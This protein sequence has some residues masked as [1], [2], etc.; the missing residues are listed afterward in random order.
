MYILVS[1]LVIAHLLCTVFCSCYMFASSNTCILLCFLQQ[2]A[3][4]RVSCYLLTGYVIAYLVCTVFCT[5]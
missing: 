5:L 4:L 2:H 3:S 1:G